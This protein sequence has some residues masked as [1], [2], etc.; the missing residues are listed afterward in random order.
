MRLTSLERNHTHLD[1]FSPLVTQNQLAPIESESSVPVP[2]TIATLRELNTSVIG[3]RQWDLLTPPGEESL[4]AVRFL[5]D[6]RL[7]SEVATEFTPHETLKRY[8][9]S[10]F[11]EHFTLDDHYLRPRAH[12]E[13]AVWQGFGAVLAH[14]GAIGCHYAWPTPL[15]PLVWAAVRG[16]LESARDDLYIEQCC[17]E[18]NPA[19]IREK[20]AAA[21][22]AFQTGDVDCVRKYCAALRNEWR[23]HM[24]M[25]HEIYNA[26][27]RG[28]WAPPSEI[29]KRNS[30]W[31][32][33][34]RFRE[35]LKATSLP[36]VRLWYEGL[37]KT[38]SSAFCMNAMFVA[39]RFR[40]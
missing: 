10:L 15:D 5:R 9:T 4:L 14:V 38:A 20:R 27:Y 8:F 23:D 1:I 32:F 2:A 31:P 11:R 26:I 6:G 13:G 33:V 19:S 35:H 36:I 12:S 34:E 25:F 16:D 28:F 21:V 30:Q 39:D 24:L 18:V 40:R 22:E 7:T 37:Q 29:V 17:L 3:L